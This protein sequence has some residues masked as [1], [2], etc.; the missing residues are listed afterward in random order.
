MI[1]NNI[2][3]ALVVV[4][5]VISLGGV[6]LIT[7]MSAGRI[8]MA[9][10]TVGMQLDPDT[11]ITLVTS[12]INFGTVTLGQ[13]DDTT[14]G[15]PLPFYIRNDG[16]V[17]VDITIGATDLFTSTPNPTINYQ[18]MCGGTT[19][20]VL[21]PVGSVVTWT[22]MPIELLPITVVKG[23]GFGDTADEI[24]IEIAIGVPTDE[25]AGNKAST[26]TLTASKAI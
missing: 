20:M 24:E 18:F 17:A 15:I 9:T 21:C 6:F 7:N 11:T 23:L 2:L 1:D 14:D 19:E 16:S 5:I 3:A 10:G 22:N 13:R 25:P 8:G 4:S 26:V 12:D